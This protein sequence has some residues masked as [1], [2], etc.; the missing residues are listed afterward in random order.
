MGLFNPYDIFSP[1][2][3]ARSKLFELFINGGI[4]FCMVV[5]PLGLLVALFGGV[6]LDDAFLR[7]ISKFG[8]STLLLGLLV[9]VILMIWLFLFNRKSGGIPKGMA[10]AFIWSS[11]SLMLSAVFG[12]IAIGFFVINATELLH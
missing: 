8:A 1:K 2:E 7:M 4:A 9:T 5:S 10:Q 3:G 6:V 11:V 12:L